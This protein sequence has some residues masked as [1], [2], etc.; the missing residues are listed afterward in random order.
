MTYF[1]HNIFSNM[2]TTTCEN[3]IF[4]SAK[5]QSEIGALTRTGISDVDPRIRTSDNPMSI[6]N[7]LA[8]QFF[9]LYHPVKFHGRNFCSF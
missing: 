7:F 4:T 1:G 6:K 2:I 3:S 5:N 9:V 8:R